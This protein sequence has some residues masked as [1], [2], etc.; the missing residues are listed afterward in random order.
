MA[1]QGRCDLL[2]IKFVA[3]RNRLGV[4]TC[5]IL[6]IYWFQTFYIVDTYAVIGESYNT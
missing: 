6:F 3:V 2:R 1:S 5:I 4:F